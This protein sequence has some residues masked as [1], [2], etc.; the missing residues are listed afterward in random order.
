MSSS[1]QLTMDNNIFNISI[2]IAELLSKGAI[3]INLNNLLHEKQVTIPVAEVINDTTNVTFRKPKLLKKAKQFL[4][5]EEPIQKENNDEKKNKYISHTY[6]KD[7]CGFLK[8]PYCDCKKKNLSTISM[9]V[10]V[11]HAS[12]M[13]KEVNAHKCDYP[14]CGKSFPIKTRLLHHIKNH[15]Q[16][17]N[18]CCPFPNCEYIDSKNK[19]TLYTHYVRK[20]M[21]YE[22]MCKGTICNTCNE[23]KNTGI[24]YHLATCHPC[25][26]FCKTIR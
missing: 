20:H 5:I 7:E 4:L 25:S 10:S 2:N 23:D 9:H 8:C 18:L 17:E 16:I 14:N 11:N 12:E 6:E 1:I 26:P 24:I 3:N 13:G 21:N 15:H 19:A 22:T